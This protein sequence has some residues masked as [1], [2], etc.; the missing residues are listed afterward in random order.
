[1]ASRSGKL[2][3]RYHASQR[4]A[5][6]SIEHLNNVAWRSLTGTHAKFAVGAGSVR[7]Y[8]AGYSPIVGVFNP[9]APDFDELARICDPGEH[10]YIAG[11]SGSL[12]SC[13]SIELEASVNLMVWAGELR[14]ESRALETVEL[15]AADLPD[16]LA[17]VKLTH[18]GPFGER[19]PE[20]GD[21]LGIFQDGHVIAMAGERMSTGQC[22]EIS[23]VCTHPAHQGRGLARFLIEQLIR[24]ELARG[25][26]PFLNVVRSNTRAHSVYERMGFRDHDEHVLRVVSRLP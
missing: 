8:A 18:P 9:N 24:R 2:V 22:V 14:D 6:M 20:L 7:R 11:W 17:L 4:G 1:M 12:P 15:K 13:W 19:T 23:G 25:A 3:A 5:T 21:Y 10:L 16:M 26:L